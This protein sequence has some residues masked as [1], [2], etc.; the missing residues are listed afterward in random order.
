MESNRKILE[1]SGEKEIHLNTGKDFLLR[2]VVKPWN[3]LRRGVVNSWSLE[4]L[5]TQLDIRH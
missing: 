2:S 3:G 5:K 4:P 1:V